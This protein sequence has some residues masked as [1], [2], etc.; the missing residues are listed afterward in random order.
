MDDPASRNQAVDADFD[1]TDIPKEFSQPF[2]SGCGYQPSAF[3]VAIYR[4][5]VASG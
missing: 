1:R 4:I 2:N 3:D 5:R